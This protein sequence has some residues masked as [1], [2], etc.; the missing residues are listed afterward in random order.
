LI[1]VTKNQVSRKASLPHCAFAHKAYKTARG[2][3]LF[4]R[5]TLSL[6]YSACKNFLCPNPAH[7]P[8]FC[9]LLPEAFLLTV[10][11]LWHLLIVRPVIY[12]LPILW[13]IETSQHDLE[14]RICALFIRH[15]AGKDP[16]KKPAG[17][18]P[19]GAETFFR[20]DVIRVLFVF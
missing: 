6:F 4:C 16:T 9:S 15:L 5:A 1:K 7:G 12:R 18:L 14:Y 17:S 20:L 2:W 8:Q 19:C 3:N 11:T 13:G 10:L